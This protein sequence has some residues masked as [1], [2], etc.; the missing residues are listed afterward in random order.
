MV[1]QVS[2]D[3]LSYW[4]NHDSY[5]PYPVSATG[6]LVYG[7][8]DLGATGLAEQNAFMA[9]RRSPETKTA[10]LRLMEKSV[11]HHSLLRDIPWSE[12]VDSFRNALPGDVLIPLSQ[13]SKGKYSFSRILVTL[14]PSAT[15][16]PRD[17]S[18]LSSERNQI[19]VI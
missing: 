7:I 3:M 17:I 13:L 5:R 14:P 1:P 2:L 11:A 15:G 9:R 18:I 16:I 6:S 4:K 10:R 19:L 12:A 8:L